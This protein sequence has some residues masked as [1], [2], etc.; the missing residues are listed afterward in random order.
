MNAIDW[1]AS[2]KLLERNDG[3]SDMYFEFTERGSGALSELVSRI[4]AMP[5]AEAARVVIDAGPLGTFN[6]ADIRKLAERTD[7]PG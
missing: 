7:F 4:V 2:A 3:G 6:A 5:S 1:S